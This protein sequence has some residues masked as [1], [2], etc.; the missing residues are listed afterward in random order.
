MIPSFFDI[1]RN[2]F[3]V[4]MEGTPKTTQRDWFRCDPTRFARSVQKVIKHV[5]RGPFKKLFCIKNSFIFHQPHPQH[6]PS[7]IARD[8]KTPQRNRFRITRSFQ[9]VPL[10]VTWGSF[11][12]F[13]YT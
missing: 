11:K 13:F 9:K 2:I 10:H 4:E 1:T 12:K 6:I 8:P 3:Q 7:K 5:I